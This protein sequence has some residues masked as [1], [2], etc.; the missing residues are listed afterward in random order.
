MAFD[1][2]QGQVEFDADLPVGAA[3]QQQAHHVDLPGGQAGIGQG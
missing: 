2:A 1:G 3:L